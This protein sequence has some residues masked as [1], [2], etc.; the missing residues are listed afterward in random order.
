MPD[1]T[2]RPLRL[3]CS[4]CGEKP[5]ADEAKY[6]A[7]LG[8]THYKRV[9]HGVGIPGNRGNRNTRTCGTWVEDAG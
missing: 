7:K 6:T 3:K 5:T 9:D 8:G 4:R 2:P 1:P